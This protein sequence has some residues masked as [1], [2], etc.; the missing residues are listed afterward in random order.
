MHSLELKSGAKTLHW[1]TNL[2]V[3]FPVSG[4]A[5]GK[6]MTIGEAMDN[7]FGTTALEEYA[8]GAKKTVVLVPD[9]TR[10]WQGV[11]RMAKAIRQRLDMAGISS[12]TWV[13][14]GGQHRPC[15]HEETAELLGEALK[16]GDRLVSHD[17][18][19]T[20]DLGRQTS[21]GTPVRVQ[22]NAA[23]ADLVVMVGGICYHD[24]A[25]FSGGRKM[26]IPGISARESIQANHG[27]GLTPEG[28]DP[29]VTCG[30]CE[31]NPVAEDMAEYLELFLQ[32]KKAFLLNVVPDGAG[33]LASYVAGDPVKAW[34]KGFAEAIRLQTLWIPREADMAVVS[35]GGYPYDVELYQATKALSSVYHALPKSGGIVLVAGLAEGM[36]TEIFDRIMRMAM[37]DFDGAL[38]FLKDNFTIP[39]YI[40]A[41]TVWDLRSRRCALVTP[42]AEVAFPGLITP[43]LEEAVSH[44]R[45][46]KHPRSV[47]FIPAGNTA[48]TKTAET[49]R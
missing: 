49:G 33:R 27:R 25:G 34:E 20:L 22:R 8:Q 17:P 44:V 45:G 5:P 23:E 3:V 6:D 16:D 21:R 1:D 11:A 14:S 7:P 37:K 9:F 43:N 2:P 41:K 46:K 13:L 47:L 35:P 30:V 15:T 39:A 40:A 32:G 31:N 48:L 26:V 24:L 12:V 29:N 42:N 10:S 19:N 4:N 36:G 18:E 28:F 38:A